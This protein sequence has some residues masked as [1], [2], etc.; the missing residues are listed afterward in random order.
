MTA[1]DRPPVLDGSGAVYQQIRRAVARP[2]LRGEWMPGSRIPSEHEMME[3]F[4]ASRMTVNKALSSLADE[5]LIVR[6]RR[7]GSFVA[8]RT[9]ERAV[10]EI[11]DIGAEVTRTGQVYAHELLERRGLRADTRTAELFGVG[12]GAPV[13]DL[14]VRHLADGVPIQIERRLVSLEAAPEA[15]HADFAAVPPGRWLLDHVAW[16]DAEHLIRAVNADAAT[17]GLLEIEERAACLLVERRTWSDRMPITWVE[18][19]NP[20]TTRQLVGRFSPRG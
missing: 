10:M 12:A 2:I 5:G 20:G 4:G 13:L 9:P 16:T 3:M 14:T 19:L 17:A 15:E 7:L 18:L 11:W 6:R 1:R 8:H